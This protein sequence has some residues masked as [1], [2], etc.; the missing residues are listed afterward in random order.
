MTWCEKKKRVW[1][2]WPL[3]EDDLTRLSLLESV[4]RKDLSTLRSGVATQTPLLWTTDYTS[5]SHHPQ[6]IA[7]QVPKKGSYAKTARQ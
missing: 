5:L 2:L 7:I 3:R 4:P 1:K 6:R